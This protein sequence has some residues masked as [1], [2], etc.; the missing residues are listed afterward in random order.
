MRKDRVH[1]NYST[2]QNKFAPNQ[3]NGQ[4]YM[5][6]CN[7]HGLGLLAPK[8]LQKHQLSPTIAQFSR[9]FQLQIVVSPHP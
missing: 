3:S 5:Q 6:F 9:F 8:L 7:E 2:K 4:N 1:L